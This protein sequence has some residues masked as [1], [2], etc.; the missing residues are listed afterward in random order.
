MT[1]DLVFVSYSRREFYFT[2][3][4]V[5]HLQRNGIQIWFDVQQLEPGIGWKTD[6]Q[7]GFENCKALVLVASQSSLASPYVKMEYEAALKANKPVY[8]VLF[9]PLVLPPELSQPAALIDFT[10]GFDRGIPLLAAV[11]Q[12][13]TPH[14]DPLPAMNGGYLPA[15]VLPLKTMISQQVILWWVMFVAVL[16]VLLKLVVY[17]LTQ[18]YTTDRSWSA[19][20]LV[21]VPFLILWVASSL[22]ANRHLLRGVSNLS[23]RRDTPFKKWVSA[24]NFPMAAFFYCFLLTVAYVMA[25][26]SALFL[27]ILLP[28]I[29]LLVKTL[30]GTTGKQWTDAILEPDLLRWCHLYNDVPYDLRI[31]VNQSVLP[32]GLEA[33]VQ[34]RIQKTRHSNGVITTREVVTGVSVA[35]KGVVP[36]PKTYRLYDTPQIKAAADKIRAVLNRNAFQEVKEGETEP[37]Y[38]ILLLNPWMLT[39]KAGQIMQQYPQNTLP[40]LVSPTNLSAL[41]N[42]TT[43]QLVDFRGRYEPQLSSAL[44]Y[45]HTQNAQQRSIFSISILPVRMNAAFSLLEMRPIQ[46]SFIFMAAL[47]FLV[48]ILGIASLFVSS[49][50]DLVWGVRLISYVVFLG[51]G[52]LLRRTV[53]AMNDLVPQSPRLL[54][55]LLITTVLLFIAMAALGLQPYIALNA[56]QSFGSQFAWRIFLIAFFV[57][58]GITL[59]YQL[60]HSLRSG[61][62]VTEVQPRLGSSAQSVREIQR[63]GVRWVIILVVAVIACGVVI[64]ATNNMPDE[65]FVDNRQAVVGML[66]A[67]FITAL[68][69]F[70]IMYGITRLV[71]NGPVFAISEAPALRYHLQKV[72]RKPT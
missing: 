17:V 52:V 63:Y 42:I 11:I 31:I 34:Y 13:Q 38:H 62:L 3:S 64:G 24:R 39:S 43:L 67:G 9:E 2:E 28:G 16:I 33:D 71:Q 60:R 72:L 23:Q 36:T 14:H 19:V 55:G 53:Q 45:L 29:Y 1:G 44:Q 10:Q 47:C 68:I 65:Q 5:L 30:R 32:E 51:V 18:E 8:V 46:N 41:P 15:G 21:F 26:R 12:R 66:I 4:L 25:F 59:I 7:Q 58:M 69:S 54:N 40:V 50:P 35:V 70:V 6:I 61:L 27:L 20:M 22:G 49:P 37:D 48:G 56:V 57:G